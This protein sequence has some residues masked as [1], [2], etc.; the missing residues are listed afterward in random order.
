MHKDEVAAPRE[1]ETMSTPTFYVADPFPVYRLGLKN[2]LGAQFC[3]W[4]FADFASYPALLTVLQNGGRPQLLLFDPHLAG[5]DLLPGLRRLRHAF[6]DIPVLVMSTVDN[7]LLARECLRLG[8]AAYLLKTTSGDTLCE[9]IHAIV[10]G[11]RC[12]L[13]DPNGGQPAA[14][15]LDETAIQLRSLTPQQ[16]R[17][18]HFLSLGLLNKQIAHDMGVGETTVK[19]HVTG[20]LHK[21][22]VAT[23]TQ[24][25]LKFAAA[26]GGAWS[27]GGAPAPAK[28][29]G[30]IEYTRLGEVRN[31]GVSAKTLCAI[32]DCEN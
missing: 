18:L 24:A 5:S 25:V 12:L 23:R 26:G 16:L 17:V 13:P 6:P 8:A 14:R 7:T 1:R 32:T 20:I 21:L 29:A 4:S 28:A 15:V 19:A 10:A 9:A 30:H 11:D 3:N 31:S 22:A 2:L 27:E